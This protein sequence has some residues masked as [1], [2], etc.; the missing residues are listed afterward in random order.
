[1]LFVQR[2]DTLQIPLGSSKTYVLLF[3]YLHF[4]TVGGGIGFTETLSSQVAITTSIWP[5]AEETV[6]DPDDANSRMDPPIDMLPPVLSYYW[7]T[8]FLFCLVYFSAA[9]WLYAAIHFCH[10]LWISRQHLCMTRTFRLPTGQCDM[11]RKHV[12]EL[13]KSVRQQWMQ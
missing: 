13:T 4:P 10:C 7:L 5:I 3:Q 2:D 11:W 1:M 9:S 8:V 6:A 12:L